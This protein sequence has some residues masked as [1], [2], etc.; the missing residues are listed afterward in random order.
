MLCILASKIARKASWKNTPP[1]CFLQIPF[2][3]PRNFVRLQ[4]LQ[5]ER[6]EIAWVSLILWPDIE[7]SSGNQ[8]KGI[9]I[10]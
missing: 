10:F 3:K 2:N 4:P 7:R 6:L 9:I 8:P 1:S 5:R